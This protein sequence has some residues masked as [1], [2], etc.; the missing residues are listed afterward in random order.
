MYSIDSEVLKKYIEPHLHSVLNQ[1]LY[2]IEVLEAKTLLTYKRLDI[3]FKLFYLSLLDN[4]VP[5][6]KEMY[7]E[8]IRAFSLG[9][10]SEPGNADKNSIEKYMESFD[11]TFLN[12]KKHGFDSEKTLIPQSSDKTIVNGAHRVASAIYLNKKVSCVELDS[13]SPCY[14]YKFFSQRN[15]PIA[16]IEQAVTTFVE[17]SSHV[18]IAFILPI[19]KSSDAQIE[20]LIPNIIY[21]KEMTLTPNGAHNLLSQIY[22][23]EAWLGTVENDFSGSKGKLVE[24]FKSFDPVKVVV[25]QANDLD[26]VLEIK[27]KIRE[28][29]NVGK[30]SI[31]ITDT[32]EEAL[33]TA[34]IVLNENSI[35][36]LNYAKPNKF[37]STHKKIDNFKHFLEKNTLN[38]RDIVIDSSMVLAAYGLREAKDIDYIDATGIDILYTMDEINAH[39]E[40]LIHYPESKNEL[41]YN[42]KYYFYFNDIK[43][44][45]FNAVY[46]MKQSRAEVKDVN[47]CKMMEALIENNQIKAL[48]HHY[49]QKLF[50]VQILIRQKIIVVLQKIGLFDVVYS[51]Y[52][53]LKRFHA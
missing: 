30:H 41:I 20:T 51:I 45:V 19:A 33:R 14:D 3:A 39:D 36:F 16:M 11:E 9:K 25:F 43:F 44:M 29:F 50:Y 23:G 42:P 17:Y 18:H 7:M 38:E 13:E 2:S 37:L 4:H 46:K 49:K 28:C 22:Y 1:P 10:F 27:E 26:E 52:K 48:I 21:Q 53:K 24:C 15:V 32:Q 12:I 6:A 5:F 35:H 34:R 47:D 8:H 31:H 40:V